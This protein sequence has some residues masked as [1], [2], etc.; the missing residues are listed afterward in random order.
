MEAISK[1]WRGEEG[2]AKTF[3]L[4]NVLIG[5]LSGAALFM[6]SPGSLL[7]KAGAA[8]F[9]AYTV[10]VCVGIWRAANQ[11]SGPRAWALLAKSAVAA[12]PTCLV[13]GTLAAVLIPAASRLTNHPSTMD[14]PLSSAT[15]YSERVKRLRSAAEAGALKVID[16]RAATPDDLLL[17]HWSSSEVS[18]IE[19]HQTWWVSDGTVWIHVDNRHS[20]AIDVI[21]FSYA[22]GYCESMPASARAGYSLPLLQ[23]IA[24]HAQALVRFA[25]TDVVRNGPGCL[26][27]TGVQGRATQQ[28]SKNPFADPNYGAPALAQQGTTTSAPSNSRTQADTAMEVHL[29]R[30]YAAHPDADAVVDSPAFQ[31]WLQRSYERVAALRSGTTQE[32]IDL[33][34]A[35][36]SHDRT[37]ERYQAER[38][39]Q[40]RDAA[41]EALSRSQ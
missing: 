35:Y 7:A 22:P 19:A 15:P 21:H 5:T 6:A 2:L 17:D 39:R 12:L 28:S 18:G 8:I 23:K 30:I 41:A 11:Y 25:A 3:W 27:I 16:V 24:P 34:H 4:Y 14:R 38:E 9:V 33:F 20:S 37:E 40:L 13:I 32:V 10:L 36:K 29:S 31:A 26:V 1:I